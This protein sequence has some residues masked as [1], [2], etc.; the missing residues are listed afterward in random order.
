MSRY[1]NW[2]SKEREYILQHLDTVPPDNS[3]MCKSHLQ[4]A[5]RHHSDAHFIPKWKTNH[6]VAVKSFKR[7]VNPQCMNPSCDKLIKPAFVSTDRLEEALGIQ[8][9]EENPL[10][11]CRICYHTLYRQFHPMKICAS[12]GATPKVGK[13]FCRHSPNA[14][15]VMKHFKTT[16][17]TDTQI[18]NEDC[19]CN[20]CYKMH[21]SLIKSLESA[22]KG[23]DD[24]L[25]D[26]I[27]LWTTTI[28]ND[29][30]DA[31]TRSVLAAVLYVAKQLLQNKAVLLPWVCHVFLQAYGYGDT[32]EI[33]SS[34]LYIEIGEGNV[35]F[36]SRWLLHQLIVYLNSYML[37]KCVHKKFGTI[38]YCVGNNVCI[39]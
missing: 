14:L 33:N 27:E 37:Y 8:S 12:C 13:T 17:G 29:D 15:A 16:T 9:S 20:N 19:L 25:N 34:N 35:Q 22:Q 10:A 5:K 26:A 7:C 3:Y 31:L 36:S 4:E 28:N 24:M 38:L 2:G 6:T 1:S 30:I 39:F 23:S 32:G 18:T 11:V 21:C